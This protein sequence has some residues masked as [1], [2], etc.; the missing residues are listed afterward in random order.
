[1]NKRNFLHNVLVPLVLRMP[2][3]VNSDHCVVSLVWNQGWFP[4]KLK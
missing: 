4:P 1:M 2:L 3:W